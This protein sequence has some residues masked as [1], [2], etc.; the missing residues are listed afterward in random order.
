MAHPATLR[1]LFTHNYICTQPSPKSRNLLTEIRMPFKR[2]CPLWMIYRISLLALLTSALTLSANAYASDEIGQSPND[3]REYRSLVLDNGLKV[4]LIHDPETDSAAASMDVAVGAGSDPADRAGLAHFLEHM[5]FLGTRK[6]PRAGDYARFILQ[7]GGSN[8][9]YTSY[10]NT[11]YFFDI[12]A[13]NLEPALDM[14]AE[15][16]ISPLFTE[17]LVQ[18]EKNAVHSEFTGKRREDGL[19]FWSARK[20]GF[21]QNHPMSGFTTG[22]LDTLADREGSTIRD[23]LIAFYEKHYSS[24]I[25]SLAIIG[26]EPLDVLQQWAV[27]KFSPIP[28]RKASRQQFNIDLYRAEDLPARM[29][30]TPLT[31]QRFMVLTFP[32]PLVEEHR[33]T[34][35]RSYIGNI[36][37]HEGVGSLLSEL[38]KKGWVSSL[39]AGGGTDTR[40]S[41]TFEISVGLNAEGVAH[42][43]DII[44]EV[45]HAIN[46]VR[47]SGLPE[48]LYDENRLLGELSFRYQEK[49]SASGIVRALSVR[50]QDWPAGKLLSGPYKTS[51][52]DVDGINLILDHMKPD[53]LQVIVV[54]PDLDTDNTTKWY[55]VP[56][57]IK[58]IPDSTVEKWRQAKLNP[59][60]VM[61]LENEFL[62]EDL[63]LRAS[64]TGDPIKL[65]DTPKLAVWHRTDSSFGVPRANFKVS[66]HSP[67]RHQ[68][69][70]TNVLTDIYAKMINEQLNE[71]SYAANLAG[72]GG[73]VSS[74]SRGISLNISGYADGQIK[75]LEKILEAMQNP[76]YDTALFN[77]LKKETIEEI[78]NSTQDAPYKRTAVETQKLLYVPFLDNQQRIEALTAVTIQDLAQFTDHL[79]RDVKV[80]VLSHGNL[81]GKETLQRVDLLKN[82]FINQA[83]T[84]RVD[85]M[86]MVKVPENSN[87]LKKLDI[88]HND[89]S[90]SIYLQSTQRHRAIRARYA[91]LRQ[92]LSQPFY[93]ELRTRQQLGYFVFTYSIDSIQVPSVVLAL[94]S[95]SAGPA[96]MYLAVEQFLQ[97]FEQQLIDMPEEEFQRNVQALVSQVEEQDNRLRERTNRYWS[98]IVREDFNFDASQLF[99]DEVR[100]ITRAQILALYRKLFIDATAGRIVVY[101]EGKTATDMAGDTFPPMTTIESISAFKASKE[102]LPPL[103]E[104]DGIE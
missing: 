24:N 62:P 14:F 99:A 1:L 102:L 49:S 59:A 53:N 7:N 77:R 57:S 17:E 65:I 96:K 101:S 89:S 48:W 3:D 21:D 30:I 68:S 60:I 78:N 45:F 98:A 85:R 64:G 90:I 32:I 74:S 88:D 63:T 104:V 35:P 25:M 94:Q 26:S 44:T 18:R 29:N 8:N 51:R 82:A 66:I 92:L 95:P 42:V 91:L 20:M 31:D 27:S 4:T 46:T 93:A 12:E 97:N 33:F 67:L 34:R 9:A 103:S 36:L 86:K 56:Y 52:F 40:Y 81:T 50:A 71:F 54:A 75:M 47:G 100:L 41:A 43:D 76:D 22:N 80:V 79:L 11:N 38:K 84:A 23:E 13:G 16:F 15:F 73:R 6:Y 39:S 69:A 83:S 58:P 37:G 10:S 87:H 2:F 19:R 5:L 28:N 72:L 55:D 61:P 70:Q